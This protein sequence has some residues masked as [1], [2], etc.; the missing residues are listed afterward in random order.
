[1]EVDYSRLT[2]LKIPKIN[3]VSVTYPS[4]IL[5]SYICKLEHKAFVN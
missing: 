4:Y 1:M 5:L 3:S 2:F